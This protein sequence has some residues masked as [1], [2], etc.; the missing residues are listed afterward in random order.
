[1]S[2]VEL[3]CEGRESTQKEKFSLLVKKQ[4]GDIKTDNG[5]MELSGYR[6][7]TLQST[8]GRGSRTLSPRV[9]M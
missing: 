9:Y 4:S 2:D 7:L 5:S 6:L 3:N 1:M 8:D